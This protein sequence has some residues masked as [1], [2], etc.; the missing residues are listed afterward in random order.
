MKYIGRGDA[1]VWWEKW[2][3][4]WCFE[5]PCEA[6][7]IIQSGENNPRPVNVWAIV[8]DE[9]ALEIMDWSARQYATIPED[10]KRQDESPLLCREVD[11]FSPGHAYGDHGD[12]YYFDSL[13]QLWLLAG[14]SPFEYGDERP[15]RAYWIGD[16]AAPV[17]KGKLNQE[18]RN[19]VETI[20]ASLTSDE[21]I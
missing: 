20:E 18:L 17:S 1:E 5:W 11:R 19:A 4:S 12:W 14:E 6:L 8:S 2:N 7:S 15:V 16:D 3:E 13:G 9:E 21:S 10:E